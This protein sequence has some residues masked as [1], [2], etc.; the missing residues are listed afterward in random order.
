MDKNSNKKNSKL[1]LNIFIIIV[2][3]YISRFS[4]RN[5]IQRKKIGSNYLPKFVTS[6]KKSFLFE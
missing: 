3:K 6:K 2:I 1:I 5:K 4:K